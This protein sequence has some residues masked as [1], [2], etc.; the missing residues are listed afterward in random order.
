MKKTQRTKIYA[1]LPCCEVCV[2]HQHIG[3]CRPTRAGMQVQ[4]GKPFF[5]FKFIKEKKMKKL[6]ESENENE[7]YVNQN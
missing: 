2:R 3:V 5:P 6:C 7:K 1:K 4:R